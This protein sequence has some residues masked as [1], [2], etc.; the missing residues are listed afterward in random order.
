MGENKKQHVVPRYYLKGFSSDGKSFF[1]FSAKARRTVGVNI[2]DVC[3]RNY[4]YDLSSD[5]DH[6]LERTISIVESQQDRFLQSFLN[7]VRDDKCNLEDNAIRFELMHFMLF[8][9]ARGFNARENISRALSSI[10]DLSVKTM[11]NNEQFREE[12]AQKIG[13]PLSINSNMIGTHLTK[14]SVMW[15]AP[16]FEIIEPVAE[17]LCENDFIHIYCIKTDMDVAWKSSF[18][19]SENPV[20]YKTVLD[21]GPYGNHGLLLPGTF[22]YMP[23]AF[24]VFAIVGDDD[25]RNKLNVDKYEVSFLYTSDERTKTIIQL[26]N[27]ITIQSSSDLVFSIDSDFSCPEMLLKLHEK[28]EI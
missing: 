9:V 25:Y 12:I 17:W 6:R 2:K 13:K 3:T 20:Y 14:G 28:G 19:T 10:L 4:F 15:Q 27:E 16:L 18:F 1:Q 24:D 5:T 22:Y 7:D 21:N 23:L 8:M 11:M 26:L